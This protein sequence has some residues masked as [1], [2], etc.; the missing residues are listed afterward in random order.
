VAWRSST[1]SSL[2]TRQRYRS[3]PDLATLVLPPQFGVFDIVVQFPSDVGLK[4]N[5]GDRITR[6]ALGQI[7][8]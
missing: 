3:P 6:R 1:G 8:G 5:D 4:D 7:Q 2:P